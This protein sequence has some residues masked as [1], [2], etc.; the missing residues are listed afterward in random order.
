MKSFLI[1]FVNK[2]H[3]RFVKAVVLGLFIA[4]F[5]GGAKTGQAAMT[6]AASA[7]GS[8]DLVFRQASR[9]SGVPLRLL[10]AIAYVESRWRHAVPEA[11]TQ[12][13]HDHQRAYG[14]MGLRDDSWF[15][16]SLV[17]AARL[18]H[19]PPEALI[20]S[21]Q[22]NIRGAAL[23]LARLRDTTPS[24]E[25]STT[26]DSDDLSAWA[27]AVSRYSGIPTIDEARSYVREIFLT[28]R[29][30]VSAKNGVFIAPAGPE[31]LALGPWDFAENPSD[32]P[33]GEFPGSVW[34]PSPNITPGA[35]RPSH[36][37]IHTTQGSFAGAVSWLKNPKAQVS[38][39]YVIRS[40][41]GYV[42]QLVSERD[43][44][45]HARCWN[46]LAIGIEHEGFVNTPDWYTDALYQSSARLVRYLGGKHAL[47]LDHLHVVGHDFWSKPYFRDSELSALNCNDHSDPG[48]HWNWDFFLRLVS[49]PLP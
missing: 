12:D 25:G 37:I 28:L 11:G 10:Q 5:A 40:R 43:R 16:S 32:E 15:G 13:G 34:D 30:G 42:K 35:I 18:L 47:T 17:E 3:G 24:A 48:I 29:E 39:H 41:D 26:P 49:P 20:Q 22:L 9:E 6:K 23:L 36:I 38:S 31:A 7:R 8:M 44:A 27:Q 2:T 45:W 33:Q 46:R 4:V 14:V 19:Q 1:G 21:A